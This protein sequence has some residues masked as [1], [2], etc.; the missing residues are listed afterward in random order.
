MHAHHMI[1]A[2]RS[3]SLH[4]A[5]AEEQPQEKAPRSARLRVAHGRRQQCRARRRGCRNHLCSRLGDARHLH[6][7]CRPALCSHCGSDRLRQVS[8]RC[9]LHLGRDIGGVR[10]HVCVRRRRRR[11]GDRVVGLHGAR[12]QAP[13]VAFQTPGDDSQGH[14]DVRL[15]HTDGLPDGLPDGRLH[16]RVRSKGYRVA[17]RHRDRALD[18]DG[19]YWR[20]R[21]WRRRCRRRVCVRCDCKLPT[22]S[23]LALRPQEISEL[24]QL[25]SR[26]TTVAAVRRCAERGR[27][28]QHRH[29][30]R[31][32]DRRQHR[33]WKRRGT[34]TRT[35]DGRYLPVNLT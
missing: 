14:A 7:V 29:E 10:V 35:R 5:N 32:R 25:P 9:L 19:R 28:H 8:N 11:H 24:L 17:H 21:C 15:R 26:H 18:L 1:P 13:C 2:A 23:S 27:Q 4:G 12:C 34:S 22:A 30:H 6:G 31:A 16:F 33:V 20:R 3:R